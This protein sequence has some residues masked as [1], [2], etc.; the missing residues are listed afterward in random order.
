MG[1]YGDGGEY[2]VEAEEP[3]EFEEE[4]MPSIST[5]YEPEERAVR[6]SDSYGNQESRQEIY[7]RSSDY[8]YQRA[9][10]N[11]DPIGDEYA[12]DPPPG[13][14]AEEEET[15]EEETLKQLEIWWRQEAECPDLLPFQTDIVDVVNTLISQQDNALQEM[16]EERDPDKNF[17]IVLYEIE[18]ERA[19]Y[20][21]SNYL[22]LRLHKIQ[23]YI[24]FIC[25][26]PKN[27]KLLS[28]EEAEFAFK[29]YKAIQNHLER[30][31][32]NKLPENENFPVF[33]SYANEEGSDI[34]IC[35]PDE[36]HFVFFKCL[37]TLGEISFQEDQRNQITQS[38]Q[39]EED[40]VES[41]EEGDIRVAKYKAIKDLLL[42][43]HSRGKSHQGQ[44]ELLNIE[45]L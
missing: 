10:R 4:A 34:Q 44:E 17:D 18:L 36:D 11:Y 38:T 41:L 37:R 39:E 43:F 45:L 1:D 40:V 35:Q 15:E 24:L 30:N 31:V 42:P 5:P 32:I 33:R 14:Y 29:Y 12:N 27:E 3:I 16:K 19:K 13:N 9:N 6:T 26:D 20:V 21:L 8:E 7:G 28:K 22:R 2:N 23:D 25:L